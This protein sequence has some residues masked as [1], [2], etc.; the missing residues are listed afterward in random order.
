[1][2]SILLLTLLSISANA[3]IIR[4]SL[5]APEAT[6]GYTR[7]EYGEGEEK[8]VVFVEDKGFLTEADV[9]VATPS[10]Q[11][12][13]G[14]D[15]TLSAQGTEKMIAATTPMRPGIDRIAI[16]V[17]GN[18]LSA[19]I[20]QS[21][22]LGKNFVISGLN[23]EEE[24]ARLAARLMGKTEAEMNRELAEQKERIKNQPPRPEPVY[25]TEEEYQQL[26][27]E[28]EKMGFHYMDRIYTEEELGK[29]L[30]IGM[31][32]P[33]VITIFGKPIRISTGESGMREMTFETAPEKRPIEA[34]YHMDSFVVKFSSGKVESWR[35]FGWSKNVRKPKDP[36]RNPSNLIIK[37]PPADM[38]ADNFDLIAF[39][40]K[41]EI[42]LKPG[43]KT[44]TTGD[45]SELL[46]ILWSSA[47]SLEE[48]KSIDS[49]CD[50]ITLLTPKVPELAALA[51][52]SKDDRIPL[53]SIKVAIRPYI[54]GEKDLK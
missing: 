42:S 27:E 52:S 17:D 28:R 1:M 41:I 36:Q 46:G 15:V 16:M 44:P 18:V 22:P 23:G 24:P 51:D 2:K 4:L 25:H 9:A 53:S 19:P 49:Q 7:H 45:V 35:P 33:D 38:S 43:E 31:K 10:L 14:V 34:G 6:P 40:E 20:V 54:Y 26:K 32:E 12:E 39:C 3:E 21:V 29:L 11:N 50:L 13:D 8:S 5:V 47:G 48:E 37:S 30:K